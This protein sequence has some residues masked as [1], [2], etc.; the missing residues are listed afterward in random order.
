MK[1]SRVL[2]MLLIIAL[3]SI[4]FAS[5]SKET[6]PVSTT[7]SN[8]DFRPLKTICPLAVGNYWVYEDLDY[9]SLGNVTWADSSKLGLGSSLIIAD[10]DVS[11]KAYLWSWYEPYETLA[12]TRSG[13]PMIVTGEGLCNIGYNDTAF[14]KCI[15]AKYPCSIG[16]QWTTQGEVEYSPVY[17]EYYYYNYYGTDYYEC[18]ST[19]E[20]FQCG[21]GTLYCMVYRW[22]ITFKNKD[23][24]YLLKQ[25]GINTGKSSLNGKSTCTL[26]MFFSLNIGYVGYILSVDGDVWSKK[27][28]KRFHKQ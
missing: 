25:F 17:N 14:V 10:G 7:S 15:V 11:H 21:L 23:K 13:Y 20:P 3:A 26:D 8:I 4:F 5:C 16:D 6:T 28:L 18:I 27:I 24:L 1:N 12:T 19:K 22:E 9:D 2:L